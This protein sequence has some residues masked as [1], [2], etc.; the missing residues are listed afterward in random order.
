MNQFGNYIK[1]L[2]KAKSLL[3]REVC[4][5]LNIDAPML[6]KIERGERPAKRAFIPVF[7]KIFNCDPDELLTIWLGDQVYDIIKNEK[8]GL[9]AIQMVENEVKYHKRRI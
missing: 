2:R 6:S 9:K 1:D 8:M 5:Q 3:Q 7:A 4:N